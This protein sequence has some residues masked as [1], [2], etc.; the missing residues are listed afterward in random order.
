MR[1]RR[2]IRI[3]MACIL[4]AVLSILD[5]AGVFG[6]RG[7]DRS[8]YDGAVATV[9]Y[10]ADG[11]TIDINMPDG[12]RSHTRIR[13]WGVDCPEIAHAPGGCG[14]EGPSCRPRSIRFGSVNA[15]QRVLESNDA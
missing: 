11:D 13:L 6:F 9:T 5:H 3:I 10:A 4:V 14:C 8:R 15:I 1:R 12:R 2:R 7:D